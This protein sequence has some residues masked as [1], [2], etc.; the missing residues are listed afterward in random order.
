MSRETLKLS[1]EQLSSKI[2]VAATKTLRYA[3]KRGGR[4]DMLL[5]IFLMGHNLSLRLF[6]LVIYALDK[7]YRSSIHSAIMHREINYKHNSPLSHSSD[8]DISAIL[9]FVMSLCEAKNS[10]TSRFSF[11]IGTMSSKHQKGVPNKRR[12]RK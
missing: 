8:N 4:E 7:M 5:L 2:F 10:T 12:R 3:A 6:T 1:L 9:L 11:L